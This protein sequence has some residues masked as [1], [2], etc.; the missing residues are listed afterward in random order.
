MRCIWGQPTLSQ[1]N[2]FSTITYEGSFSYGP[3][4]YAHMC[5]CVCGVYEYNAMIGSSTEKSKSLTSVELLLV[6]AHFHHTLTH[7]CPAFSRHFWWCVCA[8]RERQ[9]ERTP[10]VQ[11]L[12]QLPHLSQCCPPQHSPPGQGRG[13][14][15]VVM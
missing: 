15:L 10:S 3:H 6:V 7:V 13:F 2:L 12:S 11:P 9:K 4:G 5:V 8:Y 14:H 1:N